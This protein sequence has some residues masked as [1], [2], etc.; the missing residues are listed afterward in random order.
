TCS[1]L[2]APT[3][4]TSRL[5]RTTVFTPPP[6]FARSGCKVFLHW[7]PIKAKDF[8]FWPDPRVPKFAAVG[9]RGR[10]SDQS[11]ILHSS[12]QIVE[13]SAVKRLSRRRRS[14]SGPQLAENFFGVSFF[15]VIEGKGRFMRTL[16]CALGG[17]LALVLFA[18]MA[19]AE[20]SGA[21]HQ[22]AAVP[23]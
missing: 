5:F 17:G 8:A 15:A 18:G 19:R 3:K 7:R 22:A 14:K 20:E 16:C 13:S 4:S 12:C 2:R 10:Y 6:G 9:L 1:D 21:R 23:V 11:F